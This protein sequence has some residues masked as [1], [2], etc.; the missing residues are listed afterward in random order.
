MED[1]GINTNFGDTATLTNIKATDVTD[2]CVKFTGTE[3]NSAEAEING[4][5]ADGTSCIY[6]DVDIA[7][8]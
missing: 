6:S 8:A 7:A 3:D 1:L 4:T 2:I 5:G